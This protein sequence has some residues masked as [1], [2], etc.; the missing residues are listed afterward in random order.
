MHLKPRFIETLIISY[1][2]RI[3]AKLNCRQ[4]ILHR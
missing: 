3:D 1:E 2:K 4:L